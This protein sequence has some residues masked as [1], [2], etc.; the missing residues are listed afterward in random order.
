MEEEIKL[1]EFEFGSEEELP[2]TQDQPETEDNSDG[3]SNDSPE[4]PVQGDPFD[5]EGET[6]EEDSDYY[7]N[8]YSFY[9]DKGLIN[10]DGEF[11]GKPETFE[12]ILEDNITNYYQQVEDEI[13]GAVS[14]EGKAV[15]EFI[16]AQG[17][18]FSKDQ[19]LEFINETKGSTVPTEFNDDTARNYLI[20]HYEKTLGKDNAERFVETL[21]D[22]DKL[23]ETANSVVEKAKEQIKQTEKEKVQAAKEARE[24][25]KKQQEQF[26][27]T[28]ASKLQETKWDK[29]IQKNVYNEVFSGNLRA[30]TQEIV[31]HPEA[32]IQFANYMQYFDP[33]TGKI[34]E[35]AFASKT[36]S[37]AANKVKSSIERH[38]RKSDAHNS[39]STGRTKKSDR[40]VKYEF[41]D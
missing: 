36:F 22:D 15:M 17:D 5:V 18:S 33:K 41:F 21:E 20:K 29:E 26:Q 32:L 7:T 4:E 19:L 25:R 13:V 28:L 6:T 39:G 12:K 2:T 35:E 14:D 30:K 40:N 27:Q 34:D 23:V 37:K 3:N 24:A 38:F 9:K 31:K 11:D 8:L 1:P 10:H 16:L